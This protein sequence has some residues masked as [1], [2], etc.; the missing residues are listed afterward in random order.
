M[1][2]ATQVRKFE[3]GVY[4]YTVFQEGTIYEATKYVK[5]TGKMKDKLCAN[6]VDECVDWCVADISKRKRE[7]LKKDKS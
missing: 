4:R 1:S 7:R 5:L 3:D 6:H 2:K